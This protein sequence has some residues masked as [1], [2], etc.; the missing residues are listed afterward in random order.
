M[1]DTVSLPPA[2]RSTVVT[3]GGSGIGRATARAFADRGA[4]VLVVGRTAADL[5]GTAKGY[6]TIRTLA[7]DLTEADAPQKVVD[8]ALR[9]LGGIDVLVNNAA[10][11][12]HRALADVDPQQVTAQLGT[13]LAVPVLLVRSALEALSA[14][15]GGTVVNVSSS[16]ARGSRA[17]AGN[18]VYGAAKAALDFL[19]RTWAVELAPRGIRVVGVAPGL[20]D[21]GFAQRAGMPPEQYDSML[22]HVG[23][24]TPQGRVGTPEEIAWWITRLTLPEAHYLTG[25]VLPVDGGLSLT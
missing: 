2:P 18:S 23:S 9:E 7:L 8:T 6:D 10:V 5:A 1:S 22:R 21:S 11:L 13:N 16:G 25:A 20:V 12:G 24:L 4:D 15:G 14:D 17:W 3:G 19:T